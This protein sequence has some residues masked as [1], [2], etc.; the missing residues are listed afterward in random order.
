MKQIFVGSTQRAKLHIAIRHATLPT[1]FLLGIVCALLIIVPLSFSKHIFSQSMGNM[2]NVAIIATES[3]SVGSAVYIGNNYLL[4]AA[5]VVDDMILNELCLVRFEDPNETSEDGYIYT[6]AELMAIGNFIGTNDAS[7]DFALLHIC[8]L[9]ASR[10]T[11]AC[12]LGNDSQVKVKDNVNVIGYPA[13]SFNIT[14]GVVGNIKGGITGVSD[15]IVVDAKAN[16]GNSGG[17]LVNANGQL[18]GIVTSIGAKHGVNDDQTYALKIGK[19]KSALV[20]KGFQ[21]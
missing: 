6:V 20:A 15:L 2:S 5:H 13:G 18:I 14:A 16:P 3:G 12:P 21:L 19:I 1:K 8:Y 4:T 17:A 9:D 10:Y 7:E 11:Q